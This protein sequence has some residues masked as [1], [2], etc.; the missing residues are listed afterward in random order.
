MAKQKRINPV[1]KFAQ[2]LNRCA[3]FTDRKKRAKQGYVKHKR[4]E[5]FTSAL[6]FLGLRFFA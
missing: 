2:R 1:A 5:V 4:A 6:C 3:A